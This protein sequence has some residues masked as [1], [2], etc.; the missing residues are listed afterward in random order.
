MTDR[1]WHQFFTTAIRVLGAGELRL[2]DTPSWC[3]WTT[4][5]RLFGDA[6]YWT[7]GLPRGIEVRDTHI[8]D[9]G[10][11]GQ[12]FLF[13][14]LAHI[15]IPREFYW[16]TDARPGWQCGSRA[17]DIVRLSSELDAAGVPHRTTDKVLEVKV[18]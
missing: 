2:A 9:S 17:Q 15:V 13:S 4:F 5:T 6:G 8:A 14:D 11:W 3:S 12:P 10:I 16:E 18:Y 7:A 1:E